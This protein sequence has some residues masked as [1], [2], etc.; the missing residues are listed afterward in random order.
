[1]ARRT[2]VAVTLAAWLGT[3][4]SAAYA[5]LHNY[6]LH[7][8]FTPLSTP[9]GIPR[10]RLE[11]VRFYSPAVGHMNTYMV[12]LPPHYAQ[13]ARHG[14]RFPVMYLLHGSPGKISIS[15]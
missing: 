7:R 3:G 1:M 10:G 9:A 5:Y 15:E 12:Y 6:D 14:R 13:A 4:L 2:L 11:T 8:G